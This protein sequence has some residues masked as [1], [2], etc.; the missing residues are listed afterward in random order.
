MS[1]WQFGR[2]TR[3]TE[4]SHSLTKFYYFN[5]QRGFSRLLKG[6]HIETYTQATANHAPSIK[7]K[8]FSE[9]LFFTKT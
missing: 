6:F 4:L 5:I 3:K 9:F 1:F 8:L 7:L 2:T